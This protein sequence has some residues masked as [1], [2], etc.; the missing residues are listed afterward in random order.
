MNFK[1][2]IRN[3]YFK[4]SFFFKKKGGSFPKI[5]A[6]LSFIVLFFL[7][8]SPLIGR[9]DY[10]NT[11]I[12]LELD[13]PWT[14]GPLLTPSAVIVPKGSINI[15]PYVFVNEVRGHFITHGFRAL[16]STL[17]NV[18]FETYIT[19]G[20]THRM[21][22]ILVGQLNSN[23]KQ[24][25][26]YTGIGNSLI[27]FNVQLWKEDPYSLLPGAKFLFL[28]G[29]P[30]GSYQN[31]DPFLGGVDATGDGC[32]STR[33]GIVFGKTFHI[34]NYIWLSSRL[35][36]STNFFHPVS[37][38]GLN[39]Y[40]GSLNTKGRVYRQNSFPA[41]VGMELSFTKNLSV[42]LDI[43]STYIGPATFKGNPGVLIDGQS[44]TVGYPSV[45]QISLAPAVEWNFSSQ[46]GIIMGGVF[47]VFDKNDDRF[48]SFVC[49]ININ[50]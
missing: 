48:T 46:F 22:L 44:A 40:G 3:G 8:Q 32:F 14:T 31:L 39:S 17:H 26:T 9:S 20:L 27:G 21:N 5:R 42:A 35:F 43:V 18:N 15:Q 16:G 38:E 34:R 30:T 29:F 36:L 7:T 25:K 28:E 47:T 10:V 11:E 37:V 19:Y 50:K 4:I 6:F 1:K 13:A 12:P 23:E 24:G 2:S 41:S 49:A 33:I 45:Y